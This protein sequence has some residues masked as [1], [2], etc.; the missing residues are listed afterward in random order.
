M[1]CVTIADGCTEF[2]LDTTMSR[3]FGTDVTVESNDEVEAIS[4]QVISMANGIMLVISIVIM[5]VIMFVISIVVGVCCFKE[6]CSRFI[7]VMRLFSRGQLFLAS[8]TASLPG[9]GV[10]G[11][12]ACCILVV[13][14]VNLAAGV[15]PGA[16]I[17]NLYYETE[18]RPCS[19]DVSKWM[20]ITGWLVIASAAWGC[21]LNAVQTLKSKGDLEEGPSNPCLARVAMIMSCGSCGASIFGIYW[22]IYGNMQVWHNHWYNETQLAMIAAHDMT[23][24]NPLGATAENDWDQ[25]PAAYLGEGCDPDMWI[26]AGTYLI[27]M[28]SLAGGLSIIICVLVCSSMSLSALGSIRQRVAQESAPPAMPTALDD[29]AFLARLRELG[30]W[31]R[32]SAEED[33][34]EDSTI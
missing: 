20:F 5:F 2:G 30:V 11:P 34:M 21:I 18:G 3:A 7:K 24:E 28:I 29:P 12:A 27:A 25:G 32:G 15:P 8:R 19:S 10:V 16:I 31:S 33:S 4:E 23:G 9:A 13:G 1:W 26:G 14:V 6:K 22:F 17:L